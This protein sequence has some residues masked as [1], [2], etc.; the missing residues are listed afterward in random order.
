MAFASR[1]FVMRSFRA[2]QWIVSRRLSAI[3]MRCAVDVD[4]WPIST[5]L[6][7]FSRDS[8]QSRKLP[9]CSTRS[10]K[11]LQT[12]IVWRPFQPTPM[13][14]SRTLSLAPSTDPAVGSG[15]HL[16]GPAARPPA[17]SEPQAVAAR[18]RRRVELSRVDDSGFE[19]AMAR[20]SVSGSTRADSA[21]VVGE[22][23]PV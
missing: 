23:G 14:P 12:F 19:S 9:K 21:F 17:A 22:T 2:S 20:S 6:A 5:S 4:L 13:N 10:R 18:K 7:G 3:L 16:R 15:Q 8:M 1:E 11:D